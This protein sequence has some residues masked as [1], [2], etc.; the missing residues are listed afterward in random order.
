MEARNIITLQT[1]LYMQPLPFGI[2]LKLYVSCLVIGLTNYTSG[3]KSLYGG[4]FMLQAN[5]HRF[6]EYKPHNERISI[7]AE[8]YGGKYGPTFM[9]YFLKQNEKITNGTISGPG[10]HYLH[11]DTLGI[12]NGMFSGNHHHGKLT[13]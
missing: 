7:F 6:P 4:S 2:L 9:N 11:L 10:V 12:V 3:L 5:N 1:V 8:S 13:D